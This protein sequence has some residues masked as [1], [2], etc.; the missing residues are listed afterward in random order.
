[1]AQSSGLDRDRDEAETWGCHH[2]FPDTEHRIDTLG[3]TSEEFCFLP[4]YLDFS[5]FRNGMGFWGGV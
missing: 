2:F 3:L 1:M 5:V 4:F